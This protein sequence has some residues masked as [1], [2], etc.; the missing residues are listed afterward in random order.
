MILPGEEMPVQLRD[1]PRYYCKSTRYTKSYDCWSIN[2]SYYGKISC[3]LGTTG[4]ATA[5]TKINPENIAEKLESVDE[6]MEMKRY[7]M[8]VVGTQLKCSIFI[9]PTY[10]QRL[11]H[12]VDK[13]NSRGGDGPRIALTHQPTSG[14]V[15]ECGFMY[16]RDERDA[17]LSHG[18]MA[19][20]ATVN[21]TS[22]DGP[23]VPISV[24]CK[25]L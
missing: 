8:V 24:F 13:Y 7:I 12:M 11:K 17:L 6:D 19:F 3:S 23:Q 10:Y 16:W 1:Y 21:G 20:S 14:D 9:G 15:L 5:F 2:R 25:Y 22:L 4:D 18:A